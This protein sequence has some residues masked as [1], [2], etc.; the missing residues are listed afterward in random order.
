[1]RTGARAAV[2][3]PVLQRLLLEVRGAVHP[4]HDVQRATLAADPL[5]HPVPQPAAELGGLLGE[6]Q[7]Q[8]RVDG[9]RG[10]A[11]PGVA[12]VPVALPTDLLGQAGGR[13][14]HQPAGRG[15]GHQLQRDGRAVQHLPPAPGVGAAVEPGAP[16]RDGVVE[17]ALEL[18][19]PDLP[20]RPLG[21]RLQHQATNVAG[22]QVDRQL[23]VALLDAAVGEP[24]VVGLPY[25]VHGQGE[26]IGGEHGAVLG[27][28]CAVRAAA[29]VEPRRHLDLETHLPPHA[30][31]H[32]DE[33]VVVGGFPAR[34]RHEVDDLTHPVLGDEPG[35]ENGGVR[36]V[37]LLRLVAAPRRTDPEVAAP[38]VVEQG[39]EHARRVEARAAEPVDRTFRT[40]QR[41]GLKITDQAVVGNCCLGHR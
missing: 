30:A 15:V 25:R 21:G 17:H 34:R 4:V 38:D 16:E 22:L 26:R 24:L 10:I 14:R 23:H 2:T 32:P 8:Q 39:A 33:P 28:L 27:D 11:H 40:D 31:H 37:H 35:D 6:A 19:H 5:G 9:E 18:G 29:V 36:E 3:G 1:M 7:P 41:R 12:V 20:R 13:R